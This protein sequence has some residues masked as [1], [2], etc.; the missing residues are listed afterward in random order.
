MFSDKRYI[1]Y[2]YVYQKQVVYAHVRKVKFPKTIRHTS[3]VAYNFHSAFSIKTV[4]RQE[5]LSCF[6]TDRDIYFTKLIM[7]FSHIL[8]TNYRPVEFELFP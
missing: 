2:V 3:V 5:N 8:F 1:V 6:K 4:K 7:H